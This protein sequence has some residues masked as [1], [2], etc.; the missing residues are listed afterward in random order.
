MNSVLAFFL[1]LSRRIDLC[2]ERKS[3]S[4]R[5]CAVLREERLVG[6]FELKA[7]SGK[8]FLAFNFNQSSRMKRLL[9]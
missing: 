7:V 1:F 8:S 6:E 4:V 3:I 5:I 2:T 9:L